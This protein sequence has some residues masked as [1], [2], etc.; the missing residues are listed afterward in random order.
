MA[1]I[2]DGEYLF[3]EEVSF[4]LKNGTKEMLT[5]AEQE[6]I[7]ELLA[8]KEYDSNVERT[9]SNGE[10]LF[11]DLNVGLYLLKAKDAK[12]YGTIS[13]S[14]VAVPTWDEVEKEMEYNVKVIP[15][16]TKEITQS[17]KTGDSED[18]TGYVM[19]TCTALLCMVCV[20]MIGRRTFYGRK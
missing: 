5:A 17:V 11:R 15:K 10:I 12:T 14:L 16:Y 2:I 20:Y 19:A 6:R 8:E 1:D 9:D 3:W 4:D 18:L 13:P 7:A